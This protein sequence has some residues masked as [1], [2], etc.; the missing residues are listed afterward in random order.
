MGEGLL[1]GVVS[2]G[3][4]VIAVAVKSL[5]DWV[6]ERSKAKSAVAAAEAQAPAQVAL[7]QAAFAA[8]LNTQA[9]G[10]IRI[11][12][13]DRAHLEEK[14]ADLETKIEE[15]AAKLR[16]QDGVIEALRRAHEDCLGENRNAD[17]RYHSLE[18]ELRRLGVPIHA[19]AK[20]TGLIELSG[21]KATVLMSTHDKPPRR[22]RRARKEPQ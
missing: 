11:L 18:A 5:V 2:G 14:V 16:E 17:Q 1:L 9:E 21:G 15:Q 12:Q 3:S 13:A 10:F 22:R 8:A 7:S 19:S 4:A 20:A 6:N